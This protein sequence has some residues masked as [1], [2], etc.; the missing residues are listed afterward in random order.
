MLERQELFCHN[1]QS[2]VQFNL[3]TEMDGQYI[4]NCPKCGHEHYRYVYK[5]RISDRRWGQS[6][7]W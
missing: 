3:D 1:C 7:K 6:P 5:G 4:L 2:Y